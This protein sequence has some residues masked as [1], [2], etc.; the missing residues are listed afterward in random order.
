MAEQ[1][2]NERDTLR[3]DGSG[4]ELGPSLRRT[5]S[6]A[7][8]AHQVL[9]PMTQMM[10]IAWGLADRARKKSRVQ[11]LICSLRGLGLEGSW[12]WSGLAQQSRLVPAPVPQCPKKRAWPSLSWQRFNSVQPHSSRHK[13]MPRQQLAKAPLLGLSPIRTPSQGPRY[14]R[15]AA[16]LSGELNQPFK[17]PRQAPQSID[18]MSRA[19]AYSPPALAFHLSRPLGCT[20]SSSCAPRSVRMLAGCACPL[21]PSSCW[22][23][24]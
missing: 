2:R 16:N 12:L 21:L 7:C 4:G 24:G 10:Q 18:V 5:Q 13:E 6:P 14:S 11:R 9:S 17:L 20:P 8:L 23:R 3:L 1:L 22:I 19:S 15:I